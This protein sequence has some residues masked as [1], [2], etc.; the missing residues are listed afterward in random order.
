MAGTNSNAIDGAIV[1]DEEARNEIIKALLIGL[2]SFGEIERLGDAYLARAELSGEHLPDDLK[3]IHPTG[4]S[5]TVGIFA[6]ALR[7][8]HRN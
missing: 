2:D 1:L 3:P 4:M 6:S 8:L 5:D 7:S